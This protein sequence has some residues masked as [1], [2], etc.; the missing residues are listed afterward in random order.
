MGSR[1]G[2][3]PP[4]LRNPVLFGRATRRLIAA[5]VAAVEAVKSGPR[6][7]LNLWVGLSLLAVGGLFLLW[8]F[9]RPLSDQLEEDEQPDEDDRTVRGAPAPVGPDAAAFGGSETTSRRARRDRAGAVGDD[10]FR[11]E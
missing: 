6:V 11:R 7:N 9:A 10:R 1:E 5:H 8:A 4:G 2:V 3:F